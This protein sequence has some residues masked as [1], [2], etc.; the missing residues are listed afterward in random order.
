MAELLVVIGIMVLIVTLAIPAFSVITG[1]RSIDATQNQLQAIIGRARQEALGLQD[2]RGVLLFT[3]P[4]TGRICAVQVFYPTPGSTVLGLSQNHDETLLPNG[5]SFRTIEDGGTYT[6]MNVLMFDP[7]GQFVSRPWSI[8]V[9]GA[10][11]QVSTQTPPA[12]P[13]QRLAWRVQPLPQ[14]TDYPTGMA[15]PATSGTSAFGFILFTDEAAYR[16][17][18]TVN[19]NTTYLIDNGIGFL[20][21]RYNGT[22]LRTE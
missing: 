11:T 20:V 6:P 8:N 21:N 17:A 10:P 1:N 16:Q 4:N 12:D 15:R 18:Y 5:I 14:Q 9:T 22:L 7:Q 2:Y 3:D 19:P 13:T